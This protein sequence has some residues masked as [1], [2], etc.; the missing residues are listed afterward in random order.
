MPTSHTLR[1]AQNRALR[2]AA[3]AQPEVKLDPK[4]YQRVALQIKEHNHSIWA[5]IASTGMAVVGTGV[6]VTSVANVAD[7]SKFF[8]DRSQWN[9][10]LAELKLAA[11]DV[12]ISYFS[13]VSPYWGG[14]ASETVQRYLRFELIGMFDEVGRV[15]VEFSTLMTDLAWHVTEYDLAV[16]GMWVIFGTAFNK[17][18]PF[19]ATMVGAATLSAVSLTFLTALTALLKQLI[20]DVKAL[21]VKLETLGHKIIELRSLFHVGEKKLHLQ[22]PGTDIKLWKPTTAESP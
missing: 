20:S 15:V 5:G 8:Q 2:A 10:A 11:W 4:F 16:V 6:V 9:E 13:L 19:R 12:W 7:P 22:A 18:L 17:L 21:D 14:H 1:A 3:K